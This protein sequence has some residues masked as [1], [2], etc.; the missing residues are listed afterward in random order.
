MSGSVSSTPSVGFWRIAEEMPD[1]LAVV[2]PDHARTPYGELY[3]QV[4]QLSHGLRALGLQR[5]DHVAV[6][7][8]NCVEHLALCLAAIQ[9]GL[10][11][12]SINWHLV[13]PE[14]AYILGDAE[15]KV[16]V[17]HE[18]FADEARRAADEAG[19]PEPHRFAIGRVPGFRPLQELTAGQPTRRPA[20]PETG[21]IMFYTSGT[22]GRPK[23]VRRELPECSPD[24]SAAA[25]LGLFA[26]F[27]TRPHEG[28]VHVT[29]A[30]LYHGAPNNWALTSLHSGHPV[31]L[32]DRF[33]AEGLLELIERY[34]VTHSQ[35]RRGASA[36]PQ[37]QVVQAQATRSLLGRAR[38]PG[39][40]VRR[41]PLRRAAESRHTYSEL[42]K[43]AR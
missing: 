21:F 9:S 34:R 14:I 1:A 18:R 24:D 33:S 3:A 28:N 30:P 27:G 10:Y 40:L 29:V 32:M 41:R 19:L 26:Q 20:K 25:M 43:R 12:T 15:S 11:I 16:F 37:W 35:I 4:N 31:V 17:S 2:D 36:R 23:G 38:R 7:L 42:E 39:R 6:T 22:T 5:G 13:G 8:P